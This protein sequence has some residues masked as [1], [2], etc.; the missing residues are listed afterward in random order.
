MPEVDIPYES[1]K[2]LDK[3][4]VY[5]SEHFDDDSI[6]KKQWVK[7]SAKKEGISEDISKY[8]GEWALEAPQKDGL[9]GDKGLVLKSKA[10]HSAI[11]ARLQR[12]FVFN[13]K[14]LIV[15]YEV[16]LQEGQECGGAYLKLLSD[17]LDTKNLNH[18]HDKSPYSIMFG[19]DKC[20][21]DHKLHF[22]FKHKNPLNG[23]VE[24]KHC[25][26]TQERIE[27]A[28]A[29]KLP[30]LYTL[31]LKPDNM[32]EV[33]LDKK[34]VNSGSL[35]DDF[36]PSVN[37]PAEID[38][39]N[40]KKPEDWDEREKIPDPTA[41]KPEDWN[42]DAPPQIIDE[43]AVMPDGW[44]ENEPTHIP[45]GNAEKPADWDAE[46]DGEWEP[47]L[48]DNPACTNVVGCGPW[49][50]PLINNPD[51]KGK[52]RAPLIDNPNYKGKWRPKRVSNPDYFEDKHPFKMQ[53][54]VS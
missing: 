33:R 45:D 30:H 32:F 2:P 4:K 53:A 13:T 15:Q 16:L 47:P 23:T 50:P 14:P 1:P 7:S 42:E 35:L 46:M 25:K 8:D 20:G 5:F 18:F 28:F 12:P 51:Y 37:P 24:E 38:D 39:P 52:W 10:K 27:E 11:S 49:E 9:F 17:G 43:N 22:I 6:F 19:P 31:I 21:N 41:V 44:L 48:I 40:D 26:K 36:T 34:V 3:S 54:V 29:D